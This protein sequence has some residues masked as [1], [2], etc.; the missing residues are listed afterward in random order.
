[1]KAFCKGAITLQKLQ[2]EASQI[3]TVQYAQINGGQAIMSNVG[4]R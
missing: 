2:M 1:M 4:Q 3:V